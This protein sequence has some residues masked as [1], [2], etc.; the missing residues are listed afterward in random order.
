MTNAQIEQ[1]RMDDLRMILEVERAQIDQNDSKNFRSSII[2]LIIK[3]F[4]TEAYNA[5]LRSNPVKRS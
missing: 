2:V 3:R 1:F 4:R 5:K